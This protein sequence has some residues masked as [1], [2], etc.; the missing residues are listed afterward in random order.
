MIEVIKLAHYNT[1]IELPNFATDGS[2]AIDLRA[3]IAED[4]TLEVG[5]DIVIPTGLKMNMTNAYP[6]RVAGLVLPRSGLGFK[7]YTRLAN[8]VGLI[9]Q[10]YQ[11]E[12]MIKMRNE[13][14]APFKIERFDRIAQM[15]FVPVF[16]PTFVE[17][18]EFTEKTARGEGGFGSTGVM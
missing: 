18:S 3:M 12:I 17:V 11:G 9:D 1:A 16:T 14:T 15:M 8:T 2:G 10:D 5:E 4:I 7:F 13:G 6:F